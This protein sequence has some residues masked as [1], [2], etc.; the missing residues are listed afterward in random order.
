M[1]DSLHMGRCGRNE[2]EAVRLK[3]GSSWDLLPCEFCMLRTIK[4]LIEKRRQVGVGALPLEVPT[5]VDSVSPE[6]FPWW[7]LATWWLVIEMKLQDE[8]EGPSLP[9]VRG[10]DGPAITKNT[11]IIIQYDVQEKKYKSTL[12]LDLNSPSTRFSQ[13][14][15]PFYI[16][17]I[18][19]MD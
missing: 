15:P 6:L 3:P 16:R 8:E 13:H 2:S 14:R 4:V 7:L 12:I 10:P 19:C 17:W 9:R 11:E 5:K 18:I 1:L